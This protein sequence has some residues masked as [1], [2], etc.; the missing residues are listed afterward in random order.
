M[1]KMH[2]L[3]PIAESAPPRSCANDAPPLAHPIRR[4]R[5]RPAGR[6]LLSDK[7]IRVKDRRMFTADG[8]LREEYRDLLD[9][10]PAEKTAETGGDAPASPAPAA[11]AAQPAAVAAKTSSSPAPAA[12][13]KPA[14][15]PVETA[16]GATF[17]DLIALLAQS[18]S[19]YLQ[20]AAHV[21]LEHRAESLELA[22]M[23]IDLL[24]ILKAK[25]EGNLDHLEQSVLDDVLYRLRL[26]AVERT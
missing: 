13:A 5:P 14:P 8:E 1:D 3:Q 16:S 19:V 24:I 26:A 7:P 6:K 23:H 12:P 25:T 20:Q 15:E 4:S 18:A 9:R 17:Q 10:P 22:R 2:G 21:P 11:P